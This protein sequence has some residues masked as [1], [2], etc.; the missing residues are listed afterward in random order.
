MGESKESLERTR[1]Q[2][3]NW[4]KTEKNMRKRKGGGLRLRKVTSTAKVMQWKTSMVNYLA[5]KKKR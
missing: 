5:N 2:N 3:W 1:Q 4:K